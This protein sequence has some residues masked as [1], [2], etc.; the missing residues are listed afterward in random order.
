[1]SAGGGE[2]Q[3]FGPLE[4]SPVAGTPQLLDVVD[5][6]LHLFYVAAGGSIHY[7]A[8]DPDTSSWQGEFTPQCPC[9]GPI[10]GTV[11]DLKGICFP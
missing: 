6:K 1:M 7:Q 4:A 3:E 2:W 9:S 8:L 11:A 10:S 5:D